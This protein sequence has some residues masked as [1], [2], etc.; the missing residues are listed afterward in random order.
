MIFGQLA[1][2]IV[3]FYILHDYVID[4][5]QYALFMTRFLTDRINSLRF[6]S[7]FSNLKSLGCKMQH[8][9]I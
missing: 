8:F 4:S 9:A 6:S 3:S 7:S 1:G 5:L 2:D